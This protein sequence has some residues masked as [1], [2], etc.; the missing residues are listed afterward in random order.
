MEHGMI[1]LDDQ[2]IEI[3][4]SL[5][6]DPSMLASMVISMIFSRKKSIK[7]SYLNCR[8]GQCSIRDAEET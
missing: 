3:I 1:R 7:T 8:K 4:T 5:T 6:V 2:M